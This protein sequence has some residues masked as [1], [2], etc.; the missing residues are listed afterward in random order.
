MTSRL[1]A[2]L[3]WGLVVASAVFW[4]LRLMG[5]SAPVPS[6]AQVAQQGGPPA[7][8]LSRLLGSAPAQFAA[9][10]GWAWDR[11]ERHR[12]NQLLL[13]NQAGV[14]VGYARGPLRRPD[15]PAGT[16]RSVP[17]TRVG[18]VGRA[19]AGPGTTLR[20]YGLAEPGAACPLPGAITLTE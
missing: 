13:V 16:G 10:T 17:D 14:I 3:V 18:W 19:A 4:G 8:D 1:S 20:A 6:Q 15:V 9:V 5:S 7:V 2:L 11:Q 12:V